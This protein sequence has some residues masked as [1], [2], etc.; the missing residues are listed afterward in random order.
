[1]WIPARDLFATFVDTKIM[2]SPDSTDQS[3]MWP[4]C[5]ELLRDFKTIHNAGISFSCTDREVCT[6]LGGKVLTFV[7]AL[8]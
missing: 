4:N 1:M 8:S 5:L 2:T 6:K 3:P 7:V